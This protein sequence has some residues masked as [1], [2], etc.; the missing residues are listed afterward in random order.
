MGSDEELCNGTDGDVK[1]GTVAGREYKLG[2]GTA[3]EDKA[4]V[5]WL[6]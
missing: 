1:A 4:G 3:R 6:V 5:L 2:A